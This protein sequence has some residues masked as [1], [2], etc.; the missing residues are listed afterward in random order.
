LDPDSN[1]VLEPYCVPVPVLVR[2]KVKVP[3]V[4][5]GS[6]STTLVTSLLFGTFFKGE[7]IQPIILHRPLYEGL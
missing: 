3:S 2:E 4:G 1:T 7:I 6:G 5:T